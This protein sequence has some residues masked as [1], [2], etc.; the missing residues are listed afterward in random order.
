MTA[1]V[2]PL[3]PLVHQ[4]GVPSGTGPIRVMHL[5][6]TLGPGGM[7]HGVVKIANGLDPSRVVSSI[8]STTPADP[9]M[10]ATVHPDVPVIELKRRTG[11]DPAVVWA[12]ARAVRRRRPHILHTHG[13]GTLLEG[14]V[15]GRLARV[16]AIVHG[17]HGTLQLRPRQ[18]ALQR[19]A[20]R[21][22]DQVLSVSSRLAER[23]SGEVGIPLERIRVIRNGVNLA[24]FSGSGADGGRAAFGLPEEGLLVGAVGRL[25]D[26]KD[27]AALIDAV[28]EL[29]RRGHN[30]L[31][32]ISGE[33]PLRAALTQHIARLELEPYVRL[34]GHRS[35]VET[36]FAA[37]DVFVQPSKSEGMSNTILEA[38]ASGLPVV[39]TRVGGADEMVVD[40]E[41]GVLVPAGDVDR[42]V[43][44]LA[45]LAARESLRRGMGRLGR[46]RAH[47][48]F[49]LQRMVG[50]YESFY[51]DLVRRRAAAVLA[52]R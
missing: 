8:C 23:M 13:W 37:I 43:E 12:I 29:R 50:A 31:A 17:E 25:V 34:L 5:V 6:F 19:W 10:L 44:A 18:V 22:V 11:N 24:R 40:G 35:D 36:V 32:V 28:Y 26:V 47:G 51:C 41:T 4:Y 7:E 2:E 20:W 45:R 15:G 49:S 14:I 30:V 21:Q 48:E 38:M 16:P 39:A 42:L 9:G 1:Q 27:H 52:S 46:I 3:I 33:G